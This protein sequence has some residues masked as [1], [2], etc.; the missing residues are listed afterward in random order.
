[1]NIES[2][3]IE[4]IKKNPGYQDKKYKIILKIVVRNQLYYNLR[5]V[6]IRDG[7]GKSLHEC[8]QMIVKCYEM[9]E[10]KKFVLL[11]QSAGGICV[12]TSEITSAFIEMYDTEDGRKVD[13]RRREN[14]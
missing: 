5:E 13:L 7:L 4:E 3:T 12:N 8:D 9:L 6:Y 2:K 14:T 1:M 10:K 11:P